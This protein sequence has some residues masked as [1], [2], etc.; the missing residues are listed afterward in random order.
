MDVFFRRRRRML[1]RFKR[2]TTLVV[3]TFCENASFC[4]L[5]KNVPPARFL[6][7]R[8]RILPSL[9]GLTKKKDTRKG[10]LFLAETAGFEPAGDCSLTDFESAP[11]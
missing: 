8:L 2:F 5:P 1:Y 7:G 10:C 3:F 6:Y 4:A 11:L 9:F